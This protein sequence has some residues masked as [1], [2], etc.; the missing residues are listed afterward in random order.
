MQNS[1]W[2]ELLR[3]IPPDQ[4]SNLV[5]TTASGIELALQGVIRAEQEFVV[6]RGR[7]TCT[8]EGG[9][10]FFIP[11]DQVLFLGFQRQVKEAEVRRWFGEVGADTVEEDQPALDVEPEAVATRDAPPTQ[12]DAPAPPPAAAPKPGPTAA[13]GSA[14]RP[15][16]ATNK[17]ALLERLRSRRCDSNPASP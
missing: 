17:A 11:F 8:T 13:P 10:I 4:Q 2:N 5:L 12:A 15:L 6:V 1:A 7:Q 14:R 9:G 16:G 3:L